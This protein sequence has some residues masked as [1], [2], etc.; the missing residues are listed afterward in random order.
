MMFSSI[1]SRWTRGGARWKPRFLSSSPAVH[2]PRYLHRRAHWRGRFLHAR[3]R[4]DFTEHAHL[5]R[6]R[7]RAVR[8]LAIDEERVGRAV[9]VAVLDV[10]VRAG[11]LLS[12]VIARGL[13]IL[14]RNG[15]VGEMNDLRTADALDDDRAAVD[16][17]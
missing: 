6:R 10:D 14:G 9:D 5:R 11:Q 4:I 12:E 2:R 15:D 16:H 3:S 13:F 17:F 7:V 1:S 8:Q